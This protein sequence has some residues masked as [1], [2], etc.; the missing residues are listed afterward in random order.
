MKNNPTKK[1]TPPITLFV[2]IDWADEKH[3]AYVIDRDGQGTHETIAQ[4]PEAI[5]QWIEQKRAQ[6]DGGVIG[7][8]LEQA[9]GP[10]A[11]AL[12][13]REKVLLFPVNPKQLSSYRASYNNAGNKTDQDDARL[14][15]RMLRE[16]QT[17]LKCWQP[18]S[19]LTRTIDQLCRTRRRLVDQ[20]TKLGN[21]LTAHLKACYPLLLS[22][23]IS[24]TLMLGLLRRWPD[25]RKLK[26]ASPSVLHKVLIAGGV[27]N[28]SQR[29]TLIERIRSAKLL[30]T[31]PAL[32]ESSA[33]L[34]KTLAAQM[35]TLS[36][37]IDEI[38]EAIDDKMK[39]HP[40]AKLFTALPGAGKA[41]APRL[42]AA[43]GDDRERF[44]KAEN[45]SSWSGIGPITRASGKSR[46]VR[47][48]NACPKYLR[49]TFHEFADHARQWCPWSKAYYQLQRSRNMK[50]NA[51]LRKLAR[52]WI[53]I[54]FKVW[55]TRTPYDPQRYLARITIK[56]PAILPFL[57]SQKKTEINPC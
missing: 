20:R 46:S 24:Q 7:I 40:D 44:E 12:M 11:N 37:S 35:A 56:N 31:D 38:Q 3:D 30:S 4:T 15:A 2:G 27:R 10:L 13:F 41:L 39:Q 53:R 28:E 48:R 52:A 18:D 57:E 14:L 55:Q 33:F 16:R 50:H 54:L 43:M 21:Q 6:A 5:N 17:T 25:P 26:R 51:A 45:I 29:D 8:I 23:K 19:E 1:P 42:L 36:K 9:R 49:Q 22:L 34:L 32:L 47:R